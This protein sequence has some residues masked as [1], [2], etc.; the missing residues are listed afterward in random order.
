MK[1][2]ICWS[3]DRSK[4]IAE[5]LFEWLPDVIQTVRPF[6]ST[7]SIDSGNRWQTELNTELDATDFGIICLTPENLHSDWI[8]YEAG[9][10]GKSLKNGKVVPYLFQL[11]KNDVKPPLS[12]FQMEI[13]DNEGTRALINSINFLID[14]PISSE[15]LER[16][17]DTYW[18]E[19]EEKIKSISTTIPVAENEYKRSNEDYLDEILTILRT[20]EAE[21]MGGFPRA[22]KISPIVEQNL[23]FQ[24]RAYSKIFVEVERWHLDQHL[25]IDEFLKGI[26]T[27]HVIVDHSMSKM[28]L[29]VFSEDKNFTGLIKNPYSNELIYKKDYL[30]TLVDFLI[31][32]LQPLPISGLEGLPAF[33]LPNGTKVIKMTEEK[34]NLLIE[35]PFPSNIVF[36]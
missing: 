6:I 15:R 18:G 1:V 13:A 28:Y 21:K 34:E 19:F 26:N 8:L 22:G 11:E 10:L 23:I 25:D 20:Q 7:H 30:T 29:E 14:S 27:F 36:R 24:I 35:I 4:M 16:A 3:G 5:A 12:Q 17:F 32:Y 33:T 31:N 9:A 2:F